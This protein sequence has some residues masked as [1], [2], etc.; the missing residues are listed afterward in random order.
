LAF[1]NKFGVKLNADLSENELFLPG[2]GSIIAEMPVAV[3]EALAQD[4]FE[5]DEYTV[6]GTVSDSAESFTVM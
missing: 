3:A 1:G 2:Y 5:K 6:I 4:G